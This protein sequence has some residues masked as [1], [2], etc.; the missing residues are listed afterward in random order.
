MYD[1]DALCPNCEET[2]KLNTMGLESKMFIRCPLCRGII[3]L[4]LN[5][6]EKRA[7]RKRPEFL[8]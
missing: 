4:D 3:K 6:P 5:D 2:F 7:I 1:I 8:D